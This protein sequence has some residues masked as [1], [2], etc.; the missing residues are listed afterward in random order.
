MSQVVY[1]MIANMKSRYRKTFAGFIW[2]VINPIML[3]GVQSLVFKRFLNLEVSN[4]FTHL[5]SGLLPW[6]FIVQSSEMSAALL[7]SYGNLLRGLKVHPIVLLLAL[8]FDNFINILFA[9]ILLLIPVCFFE[10]INWVG[11]MLLPFGLLILIIGVTGLSWFLSVLNIFYRDTRFVVNF[12]MSIMFFL[13]PIFYP[14]S[15]IPE[16]YRWLVTINPF[17]GL[18]KPIRSSLYQ[19]DPAS[20]PYNFGYGLLWALGFL[21]L[22]YLY[23]RRKKKLFYYYV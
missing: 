11:L 13:T 20:I 15:Y 3:Y 4:F 9:F 22:G 19:Y 21:L 2:V 17:Y 5:L 6:I 18:I 23:W 1:L 8:I 10:Q 16:E 12:V 7:I 14:P